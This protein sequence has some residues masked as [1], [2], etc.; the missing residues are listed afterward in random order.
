MKRILKVAGAGLVL[1]TALVILQKATGTDEKTFMHWYFICAAAL[2]IL[3][4]AV[5]AG[6][7]AFYIRKM[8]RAAELFYNEEFD[9]YIEE[10]EK[11]LKSVKGSALRSMLTVNL[12][13]GYIE[14]EQYDRA[15]ELL[16]RTDR[17]RIKGNEVRF[18]H[19][20]NSCI[21]QYEQGRYE[22][23]RRIYD[24]NKMLIDR[25][26]NSSVHAGSIAAADVIAAVA[27][28]DIKKAEGLVSEAKAD[29]SDRRIMRYLDRLE[30]RIK[31]E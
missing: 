11:M 14:T 17:S 15:E 3:L 26:R 1:G 2:L 4:A 31:A 27:A 9:R 24:E 28:G 7:N 29:C 10:T 30:A 16:D 22:N 25:Y 19:A 20:L 12:A 21:V 13:A 8:K 18:V 5:N 23:A 6:Y